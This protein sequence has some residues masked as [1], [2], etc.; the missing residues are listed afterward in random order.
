ML[1][2]SLIP[3]TYRGAIV[4][5]KI[6]FYQSYKFPYQHQYM[7][8]SSIDKTIYAS[9]MILRGRALCHRRRVLQNFENVPNSPSAV[10]PK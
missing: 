2:G 6:S 1:K 4:Q 8:K 3:L 10:I 7:Q 9:I 5:A